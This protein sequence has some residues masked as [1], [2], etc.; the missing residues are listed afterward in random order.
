MARFNWKHKQCGQ[1]IIKPNLIPFHSPAPPQIAA[2][3][4]EKRQRDQQRKQKITENR[5]HLA[6]VR[7]VQKNLVFVVGLPPRLADPEILKRH[8]YFG[9]YGKIHKV[10]INPSTTYAGVQGPSASAYVTYLV[11]NDALRAIQSVNNITIDSRQIKTSLGTTKYCSH[12]MKNQQCP[13][14]DCMYLHELGDGEASFTKEEM[15]QGKHQEYERRLHESLIAQT[16]ALMSSSASASAATQASN[17][18]AIAASAVTMTVSSSSSLDSGSSPA[19]AMQRS[20]GGSS[21]EKS[22]SSSSIPNKE[23]WPSLSES[24]KDAKMLSGGK[25][26]GKES[27]K[28]NANGGPL[29]SRKQAKLAEKQANKAKARNLQQQQQQQQNGKKA[30]NRTTS[31]NTNNN[32]NTNGKLQA[33]DQQKQQQN[34]HKNGNK[35]QKLSTKSNGE[36]GTNKQQQLMM[37]QS[38]NGKLLQQ[39]RSEN[40]GRGMDLDEEGLQLQQQQQK[41]NGRLGSPTDS[42]EDDEEAAYLN[43]GAVLLE[44]GLNGEDDDQASDCDDDDEEEEE[45]T[46]SD[47][48]VGEDEDEEDEEEDDS[49]VSTGTT[50][51]STTSQLSDSVSESGL[52]GKSSP[53]AKMSAVECKHAEKH[54]QQQHQMVCGEELHLKEERDEEQLAL[55]EELGAM[56]NTLP[57]HNGSSSSNNKNANVIATNSFPDHPHQSLSESSSMS[58]Y[59]TP[60]SLSMH[61]AVAAGSNSPAVVANAHDMLGSAVVSSG[62]SSGSAAAM[63]QQQ[64]HQ[65]Q[66]MIQETQQRLAKMQFFEE[67]SSS[68]FGNGAFNPYIYGNAGECQEKKEKTEGSF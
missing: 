66:K 51:S 39:Q 5:K 18:A 42:A 7:V 25:G 2:F 53:M 49:P 46:T 6:N 44:R 57:N 9:K 22:S 30:R 55:E 65:Q 41:H 1:V 47:D 63:L 54:Q 3:K 52:S 10:V 4:A 35:K 19:L 40:G 68:L 36:Q 37:K 64:Q 67:N 24:P 15:H 27:N 28:E 29:L 59:S 33:Q 48:E 17:A 11:A 61:D 12:F 26:N 60:S 62:A 14:P 20:S 34:G 45:E 38:Q 8:E 13:K 50:P 23:A 32:A 16:A 43:G 21:S 58:S 31:N 56:M